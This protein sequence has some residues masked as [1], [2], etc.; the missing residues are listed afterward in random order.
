MTRAFASPRVFAVSCAVALALLVSPRAFAD[1]DD[2][3]ITSAVPTVS[4]ATTT[5]TITGRNLDGRGP[6]HVLLNGQALTPVSQSQTQIVV[7]MPSSVLATP[8]TYLLVVGHG[9]QHARFDDDYVQFDVTV[10]ASGPQ[11]AV[12]PQGVWSC[13]ST[14][15]CRSAGRARCGGASRRDW[16]NGRRGCDWPARCGRSCRAS[17]SRGC[18]WRHGRDWCCGSHRRDRCAGSRWCNWRARSCRQ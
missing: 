1:D 12:G 14:G 8:G 18:S 2:P 4:G 9:R 7:V 6:E 15:R 16:R 13:R 17:W 3:I 10:G 5:L 11:G